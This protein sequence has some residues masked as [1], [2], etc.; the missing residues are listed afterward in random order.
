MKVNDLKISILTGIVC[1]L[2][3]SKNIYKFQ[4]QDLYIMDKVKHNYSHIVKLGNY[5]GKN[6]YWGNFLCADFK[7]ICVN[8]VKEN[9]VIEEVFNYKIYKSDSWIKN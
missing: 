6:F 8:T 4:F 3:F 9:Y 1:I 2:F 5:S 7:E